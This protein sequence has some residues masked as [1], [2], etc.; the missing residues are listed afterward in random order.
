M[1]GNEEIDA[2]LGPSADLQAKFWSKAAWAYDPANFL[3]CSSSFY[4]YIASGLKG[5]RALDIACGTGI[6]SLL[7]SPNFTKVVGVDVAPGMVKAARKKVAH[8]GINNIDFKLARAEDLPFDDNYFD[9]VTC[10]NIIGSLENDLKAIS[11]MK[12]VLK[13]EGLLRF[14][15]IIRA[16][17]KIKD[18]VWYLFAK[19]YALHEQRFKHTKYLE[20]VA[21][22][23]FLDDILKELSGAETFHFREYL[24]PLLRPF[25]DNIVINWKK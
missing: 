7:I 5:E 25:Y 9:V 11:E 8:K 1:N 24:G 4:R 16:K 20:Y 18:Y 13:P 17:S 23:E 21:S 12:R 22:R 3:V 6:L 19:L 10:L 2:E 15:I 14:N